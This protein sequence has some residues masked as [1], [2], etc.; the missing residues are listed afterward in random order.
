LLSVTSVVDPSPLTIVV[1]GSDDITPTA[2][3]L[4]AAEDS[5]AAL[6]VA[7]TATLPLS[8]DS[9]LFGAL[10]IMG[11][12]LLPFTGIGASTA[13][14]SLAALYMAALREV[15]P[16]THVPLLDAVAYHAELLAPHFPHMGMGVVTAFVDGSSPLARGGGGGVG[17]LLSPVYSHQSTITTSQRRAPIAALASACQLA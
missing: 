16:V 17:T 12:D 2:L 13:P 5:V 15:A 11:S 14:A 8:S 4:V 6:H 9:T 3:D 10:D 1:V 7:N